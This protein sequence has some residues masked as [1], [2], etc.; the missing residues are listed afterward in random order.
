M[1][2]II[3]DFIHMTQM[4]FLISHPFI[5]LGLVAF[6]C[7]LIVIVGFLKDKRK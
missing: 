3:N 7:V 5:V 1:S 6:F 4:E 2:E